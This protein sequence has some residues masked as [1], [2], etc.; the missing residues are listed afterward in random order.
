MARLGFAG[1]AG[2]IALGMVVCVALAPISSWSFKNDVDMVLSGG[3][4]TTLLYSD[5]LASNEPWFDGSPPSLFDAK[6]IAADT[7]EGRLARA[8]GLAEWDRANPKG[9]WDHGVPER[10]KELEAYCK[11]YPKDTVALAQF[12]RLL[13][14]GL[15]GLNT[16]PKAKAQKRYQAQMRRMKPTYER[17]I[18]LADQGA[19]I[20]PGNA[21]WPIMR[22]ATLIRLEQFPEAKLA[23]LKAS[24][25]A[26]YSDYALEAPRLG[27]K[28]L[29]KRWG[30]RGESVNLVIPASVLFP[31]YASIKA[32]FKT[33]CM[34]SKTQEDLKLRWAGIKLANLMIRGSD[35][36]IGMLVGAA[37]MAIAV[38]ADTPR[39]DALRDTRD[40]EKRK[41]EVEAFNRR[42]AANLESKL[43][44]AGVQTGPI[45]P[46]EMF[47]ES[48]RMRESSMALIANDE[49]QRIFEHPL[50]GA[51]TSAFGLMVV[52]L[53]IPVGAVAWFWVRLAPETY[54]RS[55]LFLGGLLVFF[56]LFLLRTS[57]VSEPTVVMYPPLPGSP[58][59]MSSSPDSS[60]VGMDVWSFVMVALYAVTLA[61]A[62]IGRFR[63]AL[64]AACII[65]SFFG[66]AL[67]LVSPVLAPA[68][69]FGFAN[70]LFIILAYR[71]PD[72]VWTTVAMCL[73]VAVLGFS[74]S[75][76]Q[77]ASAEAIIAFL[78]A[79]EALLLCAVPAKWF[80][81]WAAVS[82]LLVSLCYVGATAFSLKVN[83]ELREANKVFMNEANLVREHAHVGKPS[84]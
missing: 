18:A 33:F 13:S 64:P 61:T 82:A 7:R 5:G 55:R 50:V 80:R 73:G 66:L 47:A 71:W 9:D 58:E 15:G 2:A 4:A 1:W 25:C 79:A 19:A 34:G 41:R 38:V 11:D 39:S 69:A 51:V 43:V 60:K 45:G 12:V 52:L 22:A 72:R 10:L 49:R 56:G 14:Q 78:V 84:G 30:Y 57:M 53:F 40:E 74:V 70:V 59:S 76:L 8:L 36:L 42:C 27:L 63:K 29:E 37:G 28:A 24:S 81:N 26:R 16:D 68:I 20:D 32:V 6:Q 31:H 17:I 62:M 46:V 77:S 75:R 44:S 54:D 67:V 65:T 48:M 35:S 21:Y 3:K 83:A 23:F